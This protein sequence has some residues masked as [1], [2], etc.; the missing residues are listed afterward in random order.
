MRIG[1]FIW[2]SRR[3][4][5]TNSETAEYGEPTKLQTRCNYITVMS[6]TTRGLMEIMKYGEEVENTWTVIANNRFF[7]GKI[8]V[9][10]LFWV[11]NEIPIPEVES[12]YG[13][14]SSATAIVRSVGYGNLSV[15]ITLS[16]NQNQLKNIDA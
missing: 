6:A 11:D 8:N 16:R 10:D 1:D 13:V 7:N 5:P 14:G 12:E 15:Y 9:G 3:I 2:H 4:N